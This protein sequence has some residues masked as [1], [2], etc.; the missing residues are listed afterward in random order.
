MTWTKPLVNGT[1]PTPRY[2]HTAILMS[3]KLVIYGGNDIYHPILNDLY[4]LDLDTMTWTK[5]EQDE[6]EITDPSPDKQIVGHVHHTASLGKDKKIYIFGGTKASWSN[7]LKTIN[8]DAIDALRVVSFDEIRIAVQKQIDEV[9][10]LINQNKNLHSFDGIIQKLDK[11]MY[12]LKRQYQRLVDEET[13]FMESFKEKQLTLDRATKQFEEEKKR[14]MVVEETS[15]KRIKLNVGGAKFETSISTLTKDGESMLASMFSGR[16]NLQ[17][18]EEAN[19]FIDRDGTHFRYILN[20]L[21]DGKCI[22][23]ESKP[24]LLELLQESEYYQIQVLTDSIKDKL[25]TINL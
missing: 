24:V 5:I 16:Y 25:K 6:G 9:Y 21:R 2:G 19:I 1:V 22:L 20:C 15:Q 17:K 11:I 13:A 4:I 8:I 18:D 7:D 23:P 3:S 12:E 10:E 14:M